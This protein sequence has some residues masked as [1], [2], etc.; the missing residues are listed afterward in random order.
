MN[1]VSVNSEVYFKK[2]NTLVIGVLKGG[3]GEEKYI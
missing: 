1:R 2:P 3:K